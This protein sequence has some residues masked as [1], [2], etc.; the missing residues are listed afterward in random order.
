MALIPRHIVRQ[1]DM[2]PM[3]VAT[4]VIIV[5][6]L[7]I[8]AASAPMA[9]MEEAMLHHIPG[10]MGVAFM[11]DIADMGE[12]QGQPTVASWVTTDY[13]VMPIIWPRF[14]EAWEVWEG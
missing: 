5:P 11:V 8:T 10:I 3:A 1:Q 4:G 12:H 9:P 7:V 13:L 2:D 6:I 14:M